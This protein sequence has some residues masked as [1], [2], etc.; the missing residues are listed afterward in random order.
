LEL[1]NNQG[2]HFINETIEILIMK[3]MINHKKATNYYPQGNGQVES[4]NKVLKGILKKIINSNCI[5]WDVKLPTALWAY[6]NS[7][8]TN[9]KHNLFELVYGI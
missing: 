8:K 2:W 9:T 5:D 4:T 1:I 3:F 6:Q 7:Y